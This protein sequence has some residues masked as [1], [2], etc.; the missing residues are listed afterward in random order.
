MPTTSLLL[1][2]EIVP[3]S[4]DD[5]P[6]TYPRTRL[7]V[8][9]MIMRVIIRLTFQRLECLISHLRKSVRDRDCPRTSNDFM[10][11]DS[12]GVC[13]DVVDSGMYF[14]CNAMFKMRPDFKE[15]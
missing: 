10:E 7:S 15:L 8:M 11:L 13:E 2:H 5:A 3:F 12:S 4:S 14:E 6:A 9:I 1:T